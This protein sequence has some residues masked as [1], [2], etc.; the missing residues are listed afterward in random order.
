MAHILQVL[1][2]NEDNGFVDAPIPKL[3][4]KAPKGLKDKCMAFNSNWAAKGGKVKSYICPC[5]LKEN[6]TPVPSKKEVSD[7]GYWDSLTTC[8]ECGDI[9]FLFKY[10]NGQIIVK[11]L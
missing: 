6:Q 10:P 8:Y 1:D 11:E 3:I 5:C 9:A 2:K 7:K 4:G